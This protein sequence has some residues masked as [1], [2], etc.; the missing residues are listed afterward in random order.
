MVVCLP[1]FAVFCIVFSLG[2]ALSLSLCFLLFSLYF[3]V[4]FVTRGAKLLGTVCMF[5]RE[6]ASLPALV[7]VQTKNLSGSS[8]FSKV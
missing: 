4:V 1:L 2:V 5:V 7:C 8:F 6:K 3:L